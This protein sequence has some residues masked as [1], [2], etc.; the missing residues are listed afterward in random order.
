MK[1]IHEIYDLQ[2]GDWDYTLNNLQKIKWLNIK[3]EYICQ[4]VALIG[5]LKVF[6]R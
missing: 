5:I 6:Y 4:Q 2:R 3:K 1:G